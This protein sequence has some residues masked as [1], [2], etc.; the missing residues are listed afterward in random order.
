M[1]DYSRTARRARSSDLRDR[2]LRG[3]AAG[4]A[5][6]SFALLA[7][8]A[9]FA[10][11]LLRGRDVTGFAS[12][13]LPWMLFYVAGFSAAG[14]AVGALW[15]VRHRRG[16][17]I[18]LGLLAAAIVSFVCGIIIAGSPVLWDDAMWITFTVMTLAFGI[19]LGPK[20]FGSSE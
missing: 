5:L 13:D 4:A 10:W 3:A 1:L 2:V 17:P 15:G 12:D 20:F 16:G 14:A 19:A 7:G 8:L 6:G 9:P 18:A 11:A